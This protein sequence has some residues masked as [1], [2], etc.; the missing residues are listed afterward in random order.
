MN[1]RTLLQQIPRKGFLL[2][3]CGAAG[4]PYRWPRARPVIPAAPLASTNLITHAGG[5][6]GFYIKS[7]IF[8]L[9]P[10]FV[11]ATLWE[12]GAERSSA[13]ASLLLHLIKNS[14]V[15]HQT[16][17]SANYTWWGLPVGLQSPR[18][19]QHMKPDK[20][21]LSLKVTDR[22]SRYKVRKPNH[23]NQLKHWQIKQHSN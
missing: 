14:D 22:R 11:N 2:Y 7:H 15:F 12:R 4:G 6:T 5:M 8:W 20:D 21:S 19:P 18:R 23:P 3:K 13:K 16:N 10:L 17:H 9:I 1:T